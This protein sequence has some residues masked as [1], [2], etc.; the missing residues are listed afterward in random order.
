MLT[1]PVLPGIDIESN[2]KVQSVPKNTPIIS[3]TKPSAKIKKELK[4]KDEKK[5]KRYSAELDKK[6]DKDEEIYNNA[7]PRKLP[8]LDKI[9]LHTSTGTV[10]NSSAIQ[11]ANSSPINAIIKK[12]KKR[13]YKNWG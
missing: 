5:E 3:P 9:S 6:K 2:V 11:R 8:G 4:I 10:S 7:L 12:D 1:K 13:W